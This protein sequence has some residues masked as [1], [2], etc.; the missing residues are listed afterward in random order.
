[1]ARLK[2]FRLMV[3]LIF[4]VLSLWACAPRPT[5][6][7]D[8]KW[9]H[10]AQFAGF[11]AADLQGYYTEDGLQANFIESG[12]IWVESQPGEGTTFYFTLPAAGE[13]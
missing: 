4:A 6:Q 10:Q 7:A 12:R 2:G 13:N 8:L 5:P 3:F 11:Y 1:M 9:L